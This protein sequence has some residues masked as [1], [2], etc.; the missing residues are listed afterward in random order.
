M[1]ANYNTIHKNTERCISIGAI[2]T[3][4]KANSIVIFVVF[5]KRELQ[6]NFFK[7]Y[8]LVLKA[9]C[10]IEISAIPLT[11]VLGFYVN[12]IVTRWWEQ[13]ILLP[14]PDSAA[15]FVV[16]LMKGLLDRLSSCNMNNNILS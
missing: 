2:K 5:C 3:I 12:L 6:R 16:G 7:C 13:Y 11:F 1:K 10:K 15:I 14:W 8:L 4:T 9:Y